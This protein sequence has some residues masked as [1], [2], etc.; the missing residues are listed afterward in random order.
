MRGWRKA[1]AAA[2]CGAWRAAHAVL[3][4]RPDLRVLMY[5]SIGTP[6]PGDSLNLYDLAPESFRAHMTWLA[7]S[8]H[9][10]VSL[11]EAGAEGNGVAITFDD[12]YRNNLSTAAPILNGLGLSFTVFVTTAH[13]RAGGTTYLSA[14]DLRELASLP[15][16]TVG[17]H[18][19]T[20]V[21]LTTCDDR[22]L[23][24]ELTDGRRHL[25]DLL[26]REI[27]LMSYPHGAVDRRV[28]EAVAEAGYTLAAGSRFGANPADRD[29]LCL[30]RLEIWRTEGTR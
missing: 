9:H 15:G 3:P 11:A 10:V 7:G 5:H 30:K 18:G 25:E 14:P 27:R 19:A 20:H 24:Q 12:G 23:R 8:G 21:R 1:A 16:A 29:Q 26:Q 2:A 4:A 22:P 13:L 28:R 17:A 6:V